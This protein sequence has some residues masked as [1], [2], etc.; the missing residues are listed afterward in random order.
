LL[1]LLIFLVSR[2][3]YLSENDLF[4]AINTAHIECE[5][6]G[7]DATV[8]MMS[9]KYCNVSKQAVMIYIRMCEPCERKRNKQE[10]K[11]VYKPIISQNY[12]AL[13][14]FLAVVLEKVDGF[15]KLGTRA[16]VSGQN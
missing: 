7:R 6:G 2:L 5:H 12:N 16:G 11:I 15:F 14:G 9:N 4:D 8:K 1:I 3:P 13:H 10:R